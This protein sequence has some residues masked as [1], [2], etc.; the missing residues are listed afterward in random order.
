[1][2]GRSPQQLRIEVL[3]PL[4]A[5]RGETALAV[6][7]VKRQAVL[8]ALLLRQGAVVSHEQLLDA[9]WGPVPPAGGR[10]VLPTHINSLRR[11]LDAEGTQPAESL[12]RSGKG[13]YRFVVE[14]VRLD[15]ADLAEQSDEAMRTM[16]SGDLA[17]AADQLSATL[18]LFQGEPLANLPGPLA[19]DERQRLWERRRTLRLERLKCLVPLRRFGDALDDLAG[20]SATDRYDESLGIAYAGPVRLRTSDGSTERL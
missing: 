17:S 15:T 14:E 20:L 13:W 6:G 11:V 5:W 12:I 19:Q 3:G 1:M 16:A 18:E 2:G 7:P 9:V 10:K 8:A 4:R